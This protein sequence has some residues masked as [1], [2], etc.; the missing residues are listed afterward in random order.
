MSD[1]IDITTTDPARLHA[2]V[3]Q[4]WR[5][6]KAVTTAGRRMR[7]LFEEVGDDRSAQ[8]ARYYWGACL[9][10]I[11]EQAVILGERWTAEAWHELFKRQFLG[12][13]I[14]KVKVAG[15]RKATII[16]RLRST[17]GL[18]V[19]KFSDY[20]DKIQ[21]FAATDLGVQFR[22]SRWEDWQ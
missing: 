11:S 21:A 4:G 10:D 15:R 5:L 7:A 6:G 17:T 8:Q 16:R 14:K 9:R 3:E 19:R 22:V 18:S 2:A 1:T 20:L 12:Y 13:E